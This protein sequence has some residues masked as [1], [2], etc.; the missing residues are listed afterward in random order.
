MLD[1]INM[2]KL[3]LLF[4]LI[5]SVFVVSSSAQFTEQEQK[6]EQSSGRKMLPFA[7]GMSLAVL[8]ERHNDNFLEVISTLQE[9][10][11]YYSAELKPVVD[12]KVD[13]NEWIRR[14]TVASAL[15]SLQKKSSQPDRWQMLMG[16]YFGDIFV[17]LKKAEI[18]G[19]RVNSKQIKFY[20]EAISALETG[21]PDEIQLGVR[22]KFKEF[23]ELSKIENFAIDT[24]N[25]ILRTKVLEI[26]DEIME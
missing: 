26:L 4:I 10:I 14:E 21:T 7:M 2:K 8:S 12:M 3:S 5:A 23:A 16:G 17:E 25:K 20:I 18:S 9:S 15:K 11:R 19:E 13:E 24:N 1:I 6:N 22:A